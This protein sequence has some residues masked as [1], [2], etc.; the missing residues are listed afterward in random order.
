M[1]VGTRQQSAPERSLARLDGPGDS[2]SARA[3][4]PDP[5][6][7][8]A[9]IGS[10]GRFAHGLRPLVEDVVDKVAEVQERGG[11]FALSA[12]ESAEL[13]GELEDLFDELE[14]RLFALGLLEAGGEDG[15]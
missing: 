5:Q 1:D 6:R 11:V 15:A 9:L 3:V 14:E 8:L 2:D 13:L 12:E 10:A 7:L 4:P